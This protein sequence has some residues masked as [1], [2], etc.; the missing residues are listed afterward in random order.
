MSLMN[1]I[2]AQDPPWSCSFGSFD[3]PV[4]KQYG[5]C[6]ICPRKKSQPF[7]WFVTDT[8]SSFGENQPYFRAALNNGHNP[9]EGVSAE[10]KL[11]NDSLPTSN[12]WL[13]SFR[14]IFN[15]QSPNERHGYF[16]YSVCKGEG[17]VHPLHVVEGWALRQHS[18]NCSDV[19]ISFKAVRGNVT[20]NVGIDD[21][22]VVQPGY[23]EARFNRFNLSSNQS[24]VSLTKEMSGRRVR[25]TFSWQYQGEHGGGDDLLDVFACENRTH[26]WTPDPKQ[27]RNQSTWY[28]ENISLSCDSNYVSITFKAKR[29]SPGIF[30]LLDDIRIYDI[31]EVSLQST[32]SSGNIQTLSATTPTT[33]V[34]STTVKTKP[35]T[36]KPI[37]RYI[38]YGAFS[39][40]AT[41]LLLAVI[42]AIF[43]RRK[44]R[45]R[46]K[47]VSSQ[48]SDVDD[49][50]LVINE[51]YD[52]W[53]ALP[54]A[55]DIL[56]DGDHAPSSSTT[57]PDITGTNADNDMGNISGDEHGGWACRSAHYKT[58]C[59]DITYH[60]LEAPTNDDCT[61]YQGHENTYADIE[62]KRFGVSNV[63]DDLKDTKGDG[64]CNLACRSTQEKTSCDGKTYYTLE[65][66]MNDISADIEKDRN[67]KA[68]RS[69]SDKTT[70]HPNNYYTLEIPSK[71]DERH[72]EV[73][74][75]EYEDV[76]RVNFTGQEDAGVNKRFTLERRSLGPDAGTSSNKQHQNGNTDIRLSKGEEYDTLNFRTSVKKSS[77]HTV[78]GAFAEETENKDMYGSLNLP[79]TSDPPNSLD[80]QLINDNVYGNLS[81]VD[82]DPGKCQ[83]EKPIASWVEPEAT[84]QNMKL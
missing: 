7:F 67:D 75:N 53:S 49:T 35:Q 31:S 72:G 50:G 20:T 23:P 83:G 68:W 61:I 39:V 79:E 74:D 27:A 9:R 18:F 1:I 25:I 59:D 2:T 44:C 46:S 51:L 8:D 54:S 22:D 19:E 3:Q 29:I 37:P 10:C 17:T 76:G 80:I 47:P 42:V 66:P 84:Y 14:Y 48:G 34:L 26:H 62:D 73:S 58:T 82:V 21:V 28:K 57:T 63:G 77:R 30:F 64:N 15:S 52:E 36:G 16:N 5:P 71:D 32:S 69:M 55:S 70:C 13:L 6:I 40:A 65:A 56:V 11:L 81:D 4:R 41:C 78:N 43:L 12:G 45:S 38:L 33:A 24:E 60:T